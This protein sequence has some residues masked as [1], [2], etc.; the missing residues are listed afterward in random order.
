MFKIKGKKGGFAMVI[1][2]I[3]G[4]FILILLFVVV[5][6]TYNSQLTNQ[7][8]LLEQNTN[9]NPYTI[10][11]TSY[12]L[13]QPYEFKGRTQYLIENTGQKPLI[14]NR[15]NYFCFDIFSQNTLFDDSRA[16]IY[17]HKKL[18]Y[19]YRQI[20]RNNNG[21]VFLLSTNLEE[22]DIS[23]SSCNGVTQLLNYNSS[24]YNWWNKD[25]QERYE[26]VAQSSNGVSYDQDV[27]KILEG[28]DLNFTQLRK[29]DIEVVLNY[30]QYSVYEL[31]FDKY[32][33][34][35]EEHSNYSQP[36]QLGNSS[37]TDSND[38][39]KGNGVILNSLVFNGSQYV[40]TSNFRGLENTQEA[41]I[42]F[43]IKDND[44]NENQMLL[45]NPELFQI[46]TSS[47]N[48]QGINVKWNY[49]SGWGSTLEY[50][51]VIKN[52]YW[53]FIGLVFDR[54]QTCLY[55]INGLHTCKSQSGTALAQNIS[56]L[57]IG[58]TYSGRMDE[59]TIFSTVLEDSHIDDL[60]KGKPI[61]DILPTTINS[62][63]VD[64]EELN[65]TTTFPKL[66]ENNL[67][68]AYLYYDK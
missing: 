35:Y 63:S 40:E 12:Q 51:D 49:D 31:S 55:T 30:D 29:N 37:Q 18:S 48:A 45:N 32:S 36:V 13:S 17:P 27:T 56:E 16:M 2:S 60:S 43:W 28:N 15:D 47:T 19:N 10:A 9:A 68:K 3:F 22:K 39:K 8:Q 46:S 34:T 44:P 5:F 62:L 64:N 26:M 42:A 58:E 65:I 11:H 67:T 61:F 14:F 57:K 59:V 38:P 54:G 1:S 24:S 25:W 4:L 6:S 21:S 23:V 52:E 53:N 33:Q 41:T 7:K 50:G 20:S 66:Y